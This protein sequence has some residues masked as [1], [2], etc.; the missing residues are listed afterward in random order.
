MLFRKMLRDFRNNF[1]QFA[2]ILIMAYL[3][4]FIYAGIGS[5]WYTF[6]EM[7]GE[8]YQQHNMADIWLY[9][10]DLRQQDINRL[11]TVAGVTGAERRIGID[12]IA[13][14][15]G[16]PELKIT[17]ADDP[18][19]STCAVLQ[20]A[21][22]QSDADGI[23]LSVKFAQAHGLD[24]GDSLKMKVSGLTITAEILGLM[25]HPEYVY[26]SAASD[27][28]GNPE[29]IGIVSGGTHLLPDSVPKQFNEIVVTSANN[30]YHTLERNIERTM[31]DDYNVFLSRD[32]HGSYQQ[33]YNEILQ[34]K[35]IADIFPLVF[36]AVALLTILT[37]MT[38]IVN[39]QRTQI[40]SLK[41][42]GFKDPV[43]IRHYV[44]YGLLSSSIGAVLGLLTGPLLLA[45]LFFEMQGSAYNLPAF[46]T[47][48]LPQA[49]V[50][51]LIT[52]TACTLITYLAC[53][54][55]LREIPAQALRPKAPAVSKRLWLEKTS[56]WNRTGFDFQWNFRDAL[57]NKI[58]S[59]MA[60]V[61]VTGCMALL[62]C[63][64]GLMDSLNNINAWKYDVL[65][66]YR[67]KIQLG[68]DW[69]ASDIPYQGESLEEG[70]IEVR[71]NGVKKTTG[72]TVLERDSE[73]I[74][75][76]DISQ[77]SFSLPRNGISIS[78]KLA[79][80]IDVQVGD[81]IEWHL[82]GDSKWVTAKVKAVY[83]DPVAQGITMYQDYYQ[84]QGF[85]FQPTDFLTKE[86]VDPAKHDFTVWS[87]EE[88]KSSILSLMDSM[89]VIIYILILAAILMAVV[90]LYNLGV[91]SFTEKQRE[92]GTLQV[93]GFR[94]A[95]IQRLLL[96][97]NIAFTVLGLLPGW[98]LGK[99]II[100]M[101]CSS[102][103]EEFDM[104]ALVSTKGVL[105]SIIIT[106]VTSVIVNLLFS[107]K[108]KKIDMVTAL[109]GVE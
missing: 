31:G 51:T 72:L 37:T 46:H 29:N 103:G 45:P 87:I 10:S 21:P 86:N 88:L 101:I 3:A 14:L 105:L 12:G 56:L 91:L 61:G 40:G 38:R 104:V 99:S 78:Y 11:Q 8:Y 85:S 108:I 107:G 84:E 15:D 109:K 92:F 82:Y 54:K 42:L 53:R 79:Q 22:F 32:T 27:A 70:Q 39:N 48:M 75:F 5:E 1:M 36:L 41:A 16:D 106:M 6:Q 68:D 65:T 35:A 4:L 71:A 94:S 100:Q 97:Q 28:F 50:V 18:S 44:A 52:I 80:Y 74:L 81:S 98:F 25:D 7:I 30:D 20:G 62:T 13:E 33:F 69:D 67:S 47:R 90:V 19:I 43:I 9:G 23:W 59:L 58:R 83:R 24:I 57:R 102:L 66:D 89:Y 34:N 17:L 49:V 93:L 60:I 63:G 26:A 64:F 73:F 96:T 77:R 76:T 2:S 95:K 55:I